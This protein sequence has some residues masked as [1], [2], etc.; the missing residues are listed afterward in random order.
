MKSND[1]LDDAMCPLAVSPDDKVMQWISIYAPPIT[2]RLNKG[3]PG[4][5][6]T[7]KDTH[8]LMS[9]CA[10]ESVAISALSPFCRLFTGK[11]FRSYEYAGDLAKFYGTGYLLQIDIPL[12]S[13]TSSP[14]ADTA[15]R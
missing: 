15:I 8:N 10:F 9:L 11:E 3:A 5:N 13:L 12:C 4:A 1:T 7:D 14:R 2:A 6:L